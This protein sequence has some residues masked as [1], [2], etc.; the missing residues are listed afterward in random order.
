[1]RHEY[2]FATYYRVLGMIFILLCH[3]TQE[4]SNPYLNMLAQL[5]NIG[6][7]M[8]IILSGFLFGIQGGQNSNAIQWLKKRFKR[9]YIP[10]ELFVVMLLIIHLFLSQHVLKW[11]W[12]WL[13]LGVQGSVVGIQGAEQ[14][15][16]ITSILLCYLVTPM[17]D[18]CCAGSND[19]KN[20]IKG[21]LMITPAI[22]ALIPPAY[23]CTLY[24]PIC[25]YG[26]A[27]F[28]GN[29]SKRIRM[30]AKGVFYALLILCC[31][32][33]IR[34]IAR[35]MIDGTIL[36]DRIVTS[37]TQAMAAFAI[38][39]SIAFFTKEKQ[40]GRG[41][42]LLSSISFEVY[43]YH[44]MFCVGPVRLF[45]LTGNWLIDCCL[46]TIITVVIASFMKIVSNRI[47]KGIHK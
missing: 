27:Y 11:D 26:L 20:V 8:F 3:F 32:F 37:Y 35:M 6:V 14:T 2:N 34:L 22:L 47:A 13:I 25:W 45:S 12:L 24:A 31:S 21:I 30:S 28:A 1:M 29:E 10:Y 9:I 15:W 7:P 17:F 18:K 36:Y 19:R 23:V 39:Y 5:F 33:G 41:I 4:S 40:T 38:F 42:I 16:F 44:Y 46:V 43:L